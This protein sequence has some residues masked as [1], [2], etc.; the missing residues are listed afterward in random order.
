MTLQEILKL[1]ESQR[2]EKAETLKKFKHKQLQSFGIGLTKLIEIGSKIGKN[3][4]L[5][6]ELWDTLIYDALVLSTI[7]DNPNEVTPEQIEQQVKEVDFMTLTQSFS[8]LVCKTSFAKE[9]AITWAASDDSNIRRCGYALIYH[10][11]RD[12]KK[13]DDNFFE[14]YISI[15][16]KNILS[17]ENFVK[18]AMNNALLMIGQRNK[19]LNTKALAAA[20]SI[21]KIHVDYPDKSA[22]ATN[23][24][25]QLSGK[26]VQ[27]KIQN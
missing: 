4:K 19:N 23:C 13:L 20:K 7:V 26:A 27:E 15:I 22:V 17:E 12:E 8:N 5:A 11:A 6:T 24:Y 21:G 9:K 16:E 10:L 25:E 1:L 14:N 2:N 3:H 18:D